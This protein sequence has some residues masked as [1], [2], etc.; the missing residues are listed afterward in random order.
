MKRKSLLLLSAI[1]L[2]SCGG[3]APSETSSSS[4]AAPSTT[5][6]EESTSTAESESS[7]QSGP[8]KELTYR[9][10]DLGTEAQNNEERQLVKAFEEAENVTVHIVE[11]PGT[12][13]AYWDGIKASIFNG[14][15]RA[16][17]MMVPNLDWPLASQYLLDIKN[18]TS[19]DE[20][21]AKVPSS[22][23]EACSFKSGVYALPARMNLQGYFINTTLVE[24]TLGVR[25]DNIDCYSSFD[26][27]EN[28]I[29]KAYDNNNVVGLDSPAHFIDTMASVLDETGEMGY[30]TW[31]G[32]NYHLDSEAFITGV[33]KGRA[34]FDAG[35]TLDS[36]DEAKR[37]ALGLD[38]EVE[39]KVDAWNK[40]KLAIRYGYTYEITDMLDNNTLNQSY[41]F[42]GNP[43]GKISIVGDYYGIYKDTK[44]PELAYKFAK[45]MSF[46][47]QGFLKRMELYTPKGSVNS[48]PLTNDEDLIEQYFEL[49]GSTSEFSG[50]EQAYEYIQESSMVEG[51][52]VIPGFLSAR[53]NKKTGIAIGEIENATTFELLNACIVGGEDIAQYADQLNTLANKTYSDW[54][55]LYG[56][57]YK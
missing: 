41:K 30:F 53:Q 29:N 48:L 8:K 51:V 55:K 32:A 38:P 27:I 25:T 3:G 31:D 20:E 40:A 45:W 49:F 7:S 5:S 35:K 43:G 21:F 9:S 26:K 54:M 13:N 36:Y 24:G 15:D 6:K 37:E 19:A 4:S 28:I 2:A 42:V 23:R 33:Q 50:I 18:M 44:E 16:D 11:N 52:K 34:L 10:W 22:I 46:G 17:V 12:G 56:E 57:A 1:A 39:A 14:I 47:K